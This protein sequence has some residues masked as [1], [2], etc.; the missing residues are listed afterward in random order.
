MLPRRRPR[1]AAA[2]VGLLAGVALLLAAV[3][4]GGMSSPTRSDPV[5]AVVSAV[6]H[7]DLSASAAQPRDDH[8]SWGASLL[9]GPLGL[10]LTLLAVVLALT[11]L[12][13]VE[14]PRHR[15]PALAAARHRGPPAVV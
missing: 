15:A 4:D 12:V 2:V 5:G 1:R 6:P 7:G 11:A 13:A 10:D 14:G 9:P 8:H 3:L